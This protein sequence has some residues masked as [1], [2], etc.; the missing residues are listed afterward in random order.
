MTPSPDPAVTIRTTRETE[1]AGGWVFEMEIDFDPDHCRRI[2]VHLAW[3]DYNLWSPSGMARPVD[4]AT[5][6][7]RMFLGSL[8][9]Q[10][11]PAKIVAGQIRR[12]VSD[13]D[14]QIAVLIGP[15]LR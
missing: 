6:V 10:D 2:T 11:L 14:R 12:L 4:V 9:A 8:S 15:S 1:Q 13:A 7:T 5:V 3:A